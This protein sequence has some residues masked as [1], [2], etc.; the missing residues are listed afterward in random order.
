MTGENTIHRDNFNEVVIPGDL[1][2]LLKWTEIDQRIV[3][4]MKA[5][6]TQYAAQVDA[7][8]LDECSKVA[9]KFGIAVDEERLVQ[10]LTD[11]QKFYCEGYRAGK[12]AAMDEIVRCKDCKHNNAEKALRKGGIWCEYWGTDP[13]PDD[14]CKR[15]E[16]RA[17][18]ATD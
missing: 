18:N 17:D 1:Q 10:A 13:N 7:A 5:I 8:V 16:R 3:D 12:A 4:T 6:V 15:G 14:F 11:A 2:D 9:I